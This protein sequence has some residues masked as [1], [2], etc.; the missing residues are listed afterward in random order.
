M[1]S[2]LMFI[3]IF[4]FLIHLTESLAYSMRLAGIR[5]KQ[6]AIA[7]SFVTTTLLISRLS[8]MFQ[9]PILGAMVDGA[10]IQKS[11]FALSALENNFRVIIFAAFLG[12]LSGALLTPTMVRLFQA[13]IKKFLR[14]GSLPRIFFAIFKPKNALKIIQSFR[15]PRLA[16]LRTISLKNI[17]K[18]F[19]ILNMFVAAVYTIGVL[20]SLLAGAYLPDLRSTAIQLS[21]IVN[22][23]ATILF[24][25]FVDPA[26]ARITDQAMHKKRSENDVRSVVFYLL[27]G[28]LLGTLILAQLFFKPFTVYIM[29]VTKVLAKYFM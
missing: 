14:H 28:R 6:I 17:P 15:L 5:T 16:S 10:I 20:C 7:M 26:G 19:L 23:I 21:G 12:S 24:T 25:I 27:A 22:G 3:C 9:A 18:T 11:L 4:T 29:T 13:A 8:N 1:I 2:P